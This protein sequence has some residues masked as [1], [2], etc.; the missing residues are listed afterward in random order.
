MITRDD[1]VSCY[2]FVLGREPESEEAVQHYVN[3]GIADWSALR[4]VFMRSSEFAALIAGEQLDVE[5]LL[6]PAVFPPARVD[7]E[8]SPQQLA[9]LLARIKEE[10]EELG[11][12]EP[13]WSVLT[14]ESYR[15]QRFEA[16]RD[17]FYESG[18]DVPALLRA[19]FDRHG[20]TLGTE[21]TCFELGCGVGRI[22]SHLAGMFGRIVAADISQFHLDLCRHELDRRGIGNVDLVRLA[23]PAAVE[24]LP[25][26][27]VFCSFIVLQHNPPPVMA[28]LLD[29]I[30]GKLRPG[31][32]AV[33]QLP[34]LA[35]NYRFDLDA[36]LTSP[37]PLHM[38]MHTLPQDKVFAI[39]RARGCRLVH[40]REDGAV[41]RGPEWVSNTFYVVKD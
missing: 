5:Q 37:E 10:W 6:P 17:H 11:R 25:E 29:R 21:A 3:A 40:L 27:D 14:Q 15:S 38:E 31:G 34:V 19:F 33:F 24:D 13:H 8:A 22:T 28:F 1:V 41:G 2:R 32:V 9:M 26:F 35:L 4:A 20:I 16:N 39:I 12:T 36:Y 30:L 23:S 18:A 7:C